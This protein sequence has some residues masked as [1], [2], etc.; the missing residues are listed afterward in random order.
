M[1]KN[2]Y[3]CGLNAVS[4][5]HT[6]ARCYFP[7]ESEYRKNLITVPSCTTH[8]EDTSKDDEYV[9]NLIAMSLGTN[10]IAYKQFIRKQLKDLRKA[11]DF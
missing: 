5:E 2:C 7:E 11:Q 9:R 10:I 6:P 4:K 1:P 8:N 3:I